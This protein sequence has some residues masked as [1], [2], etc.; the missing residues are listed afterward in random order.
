ML[1][2]QD[3]FTEPPLK[4]IAKRKIPEKVDDP[5]DVAYPRLGLAFLPGDDRE[6]TPPKRLGNL[7]LEESPIKASLF[8]WSPRLFN[9]GG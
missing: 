7:F 6:F 3:F 8:N 9:S 2:E 1:N 4:Y 5:R